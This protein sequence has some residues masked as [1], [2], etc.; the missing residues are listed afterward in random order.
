MPMLK[1][2]WPMNSVPGIRWGVV[3]E[4]WCG[5]TSVTVVAG[6]PEE[7]CAQARFIFEEG[8]VLIEIR[9]LP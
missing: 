6:T 7:A 1:G 4:L 8:V 9:R 3:A 5:P 2:E